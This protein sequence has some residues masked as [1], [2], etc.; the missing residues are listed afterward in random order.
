MLWIMDE[1]CVTKNVFDNDSL[2]C[3]TI[4]N[5]LKFLPFKY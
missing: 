5:T 3:S 4:F 2:K 1:Y